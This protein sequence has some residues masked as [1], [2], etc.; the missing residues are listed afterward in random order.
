MAVVRESRGKILCGRGN[1]R[2][3]AMGDNREKF[4]GGSEVVER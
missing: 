3:E 2:K 1:L 4:D